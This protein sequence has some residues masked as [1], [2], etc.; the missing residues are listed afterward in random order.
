MVEEDL[1]SGDLTAAIVDASLLAEARVITREPMVVCGKAWFD[2]VYA[3]LGEEVQVEWLVAEGEEVPADTQLCFLRGTARSLLTGERTALNLFQT[4]SGTATL[5]R[6]YARAVEG[7]GAMVLDTRKTLPGL[8]QAQK[9]AVRI[10]GCFNHRLGLYDG[11]LIKE[12]HIQ[13]TG[14]IAAALQRARGISGEVPIQVEVESLEELDQ[15]L[16][17][18]AQWILLDN[19]DLQSMREAVRHN[20]RRAKLEAS[21]NVSLTTVRAIAETGVDRISVGELTK[22]LRA[23][24]LSMRITLVQDM[25][26]D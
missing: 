22:H 25:S 5:S 11:I 2:A 17:E 16:A 8:R 9:Y 14:S 13:A 7:T 10:G 15:A 24:D 3:Y 1:G 6:A 19:F 20:G 26:R 21:G 12:N 4:L 23:V 18:G